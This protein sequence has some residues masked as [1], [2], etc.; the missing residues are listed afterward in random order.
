MPEREA[1]KVRQLVSKSTEMGHPV[2]VP[3]KAFLKPCLD[4]AMLFASCG[5]AHP[6]PPLFHPKNIAGSDI[7]KLKSHNAIWRHWAER[8]RINFLVAGNKL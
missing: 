5:C 3:T 6:L 4:V 7:I 2:H 8:G 1:H